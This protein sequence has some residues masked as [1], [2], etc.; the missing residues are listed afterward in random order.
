M[1]GKL[2]L[3]GVNSLH[4]TATRSVP[5][6]GSLPEIQSEST[7]QS[8]VQNSY[9]TD[10]PLMPDTTVISLLGWEGWA[11]SNNGQIHN[12]FIPNPKNQIHLS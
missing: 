1:C 8:T 9:L 4:R 6:P 2:N 10:R 7:E 3:R 11:A 5:A 12:R